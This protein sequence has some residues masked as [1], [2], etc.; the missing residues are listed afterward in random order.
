MVKKIFL[1]LIILIICLSITLP[2]FADNNAKV[3]TEN[4]RPSLSGDT[5]E[6]RTIG[7]VVVKV[8]KIVGSAL[9]VITIAIIG[10]K[11]IYGSIEQKAQYKETI[12]PYIVGAIL[13]FGCSN[14]VDIIYSMAI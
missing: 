13:L 3:N 4:F 8:I 11:Y 2:S 7:N 10:I 5:S 14:L 6:I 9:S 12:M 1:L